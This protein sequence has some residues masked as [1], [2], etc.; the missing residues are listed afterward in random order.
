[1]TLK[2]KLS[3]LLVDDEDG[4]TFV[5]NNWASLMSGFKSVKTTKRRNVRSKSKMQHYTDQNLVLEHVVDT[6]Q[7][8]D[9]KDRIGIQF[10]VP[11]GTKAHKSIL[12]RVSTNGRSLVV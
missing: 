7:D 10:C 1:M 8:T 6:W 3:R 2:S 11:S 12:V 9:P 4:D 5:S